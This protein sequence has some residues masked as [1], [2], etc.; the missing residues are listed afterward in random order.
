MKIKKMTPKSLGAKNRQ[1]KE[2]EVVEVLRLVRR[3][4]KHGVRSKGYD[5]QGPFSGPGRV[6]AYS[7]DDCR[8]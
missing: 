2:S 4:R 6:I 1:A 5:L 7:V 8:E 3:V